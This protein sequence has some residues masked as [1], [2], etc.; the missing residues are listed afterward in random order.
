VY[1]HDTVARDA[2]HR[3]AIARPNGR[4]GWRAR[5]GDA[6]ARRRCTH[7]GT[8]LAPLRL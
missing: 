5:R 4:S 6:F 2:S 7:A 3:A 8:A 1:P